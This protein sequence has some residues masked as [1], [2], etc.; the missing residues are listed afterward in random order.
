MGKIKK[1]GFVV[2][3][4]GPSQLC[5]DIIRSS[6]NYLS[7]NDDV[8]IC[9]FWVLD[10]PKPAQPRFSCMPIIECFAYPGNVIATDLHTLSRTLSY[11]GPH[12]NR[13]IYFYDYNLDYT[14]IPHQMRKWDELNSLYNHQKVQLIARSE[15]HAEILTAAFKKPIGIVEDYNIEKFKEIIYE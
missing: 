13:F 5:Y 8:D 14:K 11:P 15:N 6:N 9:L 3:R 4:L 10:G 7:I 1:I 2:G 12:R